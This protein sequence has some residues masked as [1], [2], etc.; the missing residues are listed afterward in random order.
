[1]PSELNPGQ[2]R[3]ARPD[4][5]DPAPPHDTGLPSGRPSVNIHRLIGQIFRDASPLGTDGRPKEW[6]K[7]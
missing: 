6:S 2:A 5:H 1:M 7:P 4:I 3:T